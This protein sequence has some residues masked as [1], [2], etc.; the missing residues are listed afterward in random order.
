MSKRIYRGVAL[1]SLGLLA[2]CLIVLV[3]MPITSLV[4]WS[5][6]QVQATDVRRSTVFS[7]EVYLD[8][9][10]AP[11]LGAILASWRWCPG[12]QVL[13]WCT[14]LQASD[15]SFD[16]QVSLGISSVS[17][18][19]AK[20]RLENLIPFGVAPSLANLQAQITV[21]ELI[22]KDLSCP[23]G[24]MESLSSVAEILA[25]SLF[26]S[27][28]G[29]ADLVATADQGGASA[30]LTGEHLS[31]NFTST[32]SLS[33]SGNIAVN[34]TPELVP[35]FNQFSRANGVGEYEWKA[36]GNLPCGWS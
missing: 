2:L 25:I 30:R 22:I 31:G 5:D 13:T 34:P 27:P 26:G 21:E 4:P 6:Y 12:I 8:L 10:Q 20:A 3:R 9:I 28:L 15:F 32:S 1:S 14:A 18:R 11:A 23:A 19:E 24:S 29:D 17:I 36:E 16:G 7:G 35:L 33:Y